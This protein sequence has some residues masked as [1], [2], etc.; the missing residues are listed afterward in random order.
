M[1]AGMQAAAGRHAGESRRGKEGRLTS[2][3]EARKGESVEV[4]DGRLGREPLVQ[5]P[6]EGVLLLTLRL[7]GLQGL[8]QL[9]LA[10]PTE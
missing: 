6:P 9:L 10:D 5:L 2:E 7:Q 8:L 3:A 4:E 1:R